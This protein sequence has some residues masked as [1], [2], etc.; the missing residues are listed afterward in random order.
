MSN[1]ELAKE[2][3]K[4]IIAKFKIRKLYSSFIDSIWGADLANIQLTN[5]FNKGIRFLLYVIDNFSK[6]VW[7]ILLKEKKHYN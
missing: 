4:P 5:K 2:L 3:H 7:V 1:K 6:Y